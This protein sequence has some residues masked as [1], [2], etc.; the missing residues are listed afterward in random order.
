MGE[1]EARVDVLA[2]V[3]LVG[4]EE[5]EARC[6]NLSAC[7]R[8]LKPVTVADLPG[9]A[10]MA[11]EAAPKKKG[12]EMMEVVMQE[13]EVRAKDV[14]S[15]FWTFSPLRVHARSTGDKEKNNG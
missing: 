4:V 12:R 11:H 9:G 10:D 6:M 3:G 1:G 14:E 15:K 2:E 8:P 7:T 5:G 13:E